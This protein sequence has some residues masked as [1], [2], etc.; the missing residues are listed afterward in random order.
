M[1]ASVPASALRRILVVDHQRETRMVVE[2]SLGKI[3]GYDVVACA[4]GAEA[5]ERAPGFAPDL[6]LL[7]VGMPEL[8]G[9]ATMQRL[10]AAGV[11]APVVFFTSRQKPEDLARYAQSGALATIAK[12]F[13]PLKVARQLRR[14]WD[15]RA[16]RAR[17]PA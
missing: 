9:P 6:V 12:P 1:N 2:F 13:D 11:A 7:D 5:L 3:Y 17:A 15:G 10:R 14:I 16:Q 4:S 8:D